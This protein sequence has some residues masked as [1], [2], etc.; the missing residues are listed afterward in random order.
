MS[1]V[2]QMQ[3]GEDPVLYRPRYGN[4]DLEFKLLATNTRQPD[5]VAVGSSRILQFRSMF[6]NRNSHAF[7]NAAGPAWQLEH[8]IALV[9][10]LE[11]TPQIL[12]ISLD[13]P[14]FNDAYP[15]DPFQPSLE[16]TSDFDHLFMVNRSVMQSFLEGESLDIGRMLERR[17]PGYGGLALGLRA[18]RD[19]HGF[20]NDGSEQYGDFFVAQ[21]LHPENER[22]R[23]LSLLENGQDMYAR[24]SE[25]SESA[26]QQLEQL[27]RYCDEHGIYV[28]GFL[29]SYMPTLYQE[30]IAGGQHQYIEALPE[31]LEP[32]F[33]NYGFAFFDFSD[34]AVLGATDDDFIDG[35]H[36][37]ERINLRLYT[38]TVRALPEVLSAYSDVERLE[39][40][41]E[42]ATNTFDVFGNQF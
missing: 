6:F 22:A 29:P 14:W 36:A 12:I 21:Y 11:Y 17:E 31:Q 5:V 25:V 10:G 35:W 4:R 37:S 8:V 33:A 27:L 20:R 30:M 18:I 13:H 9:E 3:M 32:L 15:G 39:S 7:Y 16:P 40:D 19:G 38:E 23:H 28:I 24:G 41:D 26:L 34:G 2:V 42:G 1:T